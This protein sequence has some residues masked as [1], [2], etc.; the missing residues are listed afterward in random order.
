MATGKASNEERPSSSRSS[1]RALE[2]PQGST[3]PDEHS[4]QPAKRSRVS[5]ACDQ[6]RA[7]RERCDGSHPKCQTCSTQNRECSYHEQ[8]KKRGIQP[9]YIR[10]LEL[11]LAWIFENFPATEAKLAKNLPDDDRVH[12]LI[13]GKDQAAS[14][15][16]HLAWRNCI[17]NR[18]IEQMLSGAEIERQTQSIHMAL[19]SGNNS[20]LPYSSPPLS[21]PS[22]QS[23]MRQMVDDATAT[24]EPFRSGHPGHVPTYTT[25]GISEDA[26]HRLPDSAWTLL[27]Y[28]FAFTHSWLPMTE[29]HS[30]L[31]VMYSYPPEGL[32]YEQ[33]KGAEHAEL[34][35]I[36]SLAG[37]QLLEENS[38]DEVHRIRQITESLIPTVNASYELPHI[39][40]MML[41]ALAD[42][43][44]ER[45]LAAWL[46]MGCVVRLLYLFKLL[47][48]L[49]Q[50]A[51]WCRHIHLV[52]FVLESAL[53]M[54][55]KAP[56][57]LTVSYIQAVGTVEED[58]LDE[59]AP[60]QDPLASTQSG[61]I[62]RAPVRAFSTLNELVRISMRSAE[63]HYIGRDPN[64][65][66]TGAENSAFFSLLKNAGSK[67]D[68]V[69][70]SVLVAAHIDN[71]DEFQRLPNQAQEVDP[72]WALP[73]PAKPQPRHTSGPTNVEQHHA[74]MSI[75]NEATVNV[76]GSSPA[77]SHS[78]P[79]SS[80]SW[81]P[82][83]H[84][85]PAFQ[86]TT[87]PAGVFDNSTDIFEELASLERQDST[88]YPQFMRNLGFPD[89]ELAEF[90]GHDYQP[91][92]PLMAYLQPTPF[93]AFP[94]AA[95]QTGADQG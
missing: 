87:S 28:Y 26:R 27:E 1:K 77:I 93:D 85:S 8:P 42:A 46:R 16:L 19:D 82:D 66:G 69:Q 23:G 88:Q 32:L 92:D 59:W 90:F 13:S 78:A 75:P 72:F 79:F 57:H 37:T 51:K 54:H 2:A 33:I 73:G 18:Q 34:W 11:A 24:V 70:P 63:S 49:G 4:A 89:L 68:R 81:M 6:C 47:E 41:L 60:W 91:S 71:D 29:K 58:G 52:A 61:G 38:R 65:H 9:N 12:K 80:A 31:K 94:N 67:R 30:I 10:T 20:I 22:D 64:P 15:A 48:H 7:S 95:A 36:M 76:S 62:N 25:T 40:A 39:K 14:E 74:F 55:L 86:T 3:H 45:M 17:I 50:T 44:E 53:A 35:A 84:M 5:R 56:S 21:A 83:A 43:Q